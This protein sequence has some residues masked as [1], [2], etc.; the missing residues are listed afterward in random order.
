[1]ERE[2]EGKRGVDEDKQDRSN[3][4]R[5]KEERTIMRDVMEKEVVQAIGRMKKKKAAEIDEI[6]MEAWMY[7]GEAIKKGLTELIRRM[8]A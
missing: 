5:R 2:E 7:G 6:P 3:G 1:M 4:G 8:R